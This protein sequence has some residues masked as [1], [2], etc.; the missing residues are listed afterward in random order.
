MLIERWWS[1]DAYNIG[2]AAGPAGLVIVDL[3]V[4]PTGVAL[5]AAWAGCRHG[6]DVLERLAARAGAPY[7]GDTRTVRTPSGG[8]HLIFTRPP[9]VELRNSRGKI[10]PYVDS[11]GVGGFGLAA[12][13][14]IPEGRYR[15]LNFSAPSQMPMWL[16]GLFGTEPAPPVML[17]QRT[18]PPGAVSAYVRWKVNHWARMVANAVQPGRHDTLLRAAVALGGLV[19]AGMLGEQEAADALHRAGQTHVGVQEFTEREL[20]R[21]ISDGISYGIAHSREVRPT[22]RGRS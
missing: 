20:D 1:Q 13:S 10:G 11:R 15:T 2:L 4:P 6:K 16:A 21:T 3:D 18:L 22:G 5:P 12:G 19:G 7:P 9:G 8:W 17:P 14:T